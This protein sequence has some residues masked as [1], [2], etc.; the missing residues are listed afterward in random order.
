MIRGTLAHEPRKQEVLEN[1]EMI[2]NS[3][4]PIHSICIDLQ[5]CLVLKLTL[6]EVTPLLAFGAET[7]DPACHE[8]PGK[9]ADEVVVRG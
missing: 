3:L 4:L 2:A 1:P 6:C 8:Q 9:F 7:E 5:A